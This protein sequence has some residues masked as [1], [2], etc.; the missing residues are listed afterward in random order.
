MI[1]IIKTN[2]RCYLNK[3]DF[4]DIED[5]LRDLKADYESFNLPET[6]EELKTM[7]KETEKETDNIRCVIYKDEIDVIVWDKERKHIVGI[8]EF[9][10]DGKKIYLGMGTGFSVPI[11]IPRV[12]SFIKSLIGE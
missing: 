12:W 10:Y 2:K 4:I 9:Y 5:I 8:A 3:Q 7:C 11:E 6:F 1:N